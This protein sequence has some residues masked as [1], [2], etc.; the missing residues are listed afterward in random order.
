MAWSW[1]EPASGVTDD[2][3]ALSFTQDY[4]HGADLT[5]YGKEVV[6]PPRSASCD[7]VPM[8]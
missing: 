1:D 6:V 5:T 2:S 7:G 3:F 4:T 8:R